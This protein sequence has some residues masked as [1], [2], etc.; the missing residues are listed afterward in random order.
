MYDIYLACKFTLASVEEKEPFFLL[1][2]VLHSLDACSLHLI[3]RKQMKC[4]K[5]SAGHKKIDLVLHSSHLYLSGRSHVTYNFS[6]Y[7]TEISLKVYGCTSV[8]HW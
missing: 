2:D 3:S 7:R 4:R 5:L 6:L 1:K 8:L